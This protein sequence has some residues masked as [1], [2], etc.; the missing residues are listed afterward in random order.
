MIIYSDS[1][2]QE[3]INQTINLVNSKKIF[4]NIN[5]ELCILFCKY[6]LK[7]L[8]IE[9]TNL[10]FEKNKGGSSYINNKIT[11]DEKDLKK[12]TSYYNLDSIAH[13]TRH[14]F[15]DQTKTK[16]SLNSHIEFSYPLEYFNPILFSL[17]TN[18]D[19]NLF[20]FYN[21]SKHESGARNYSLDIIDEFLNSILNSSD[22]VSKSKLWA[23]K[24]ISLNEKA[25]LVEN[26][27]FLKYT[28][29]SKSQQPLIK[30]LVENYINDVINLQNNP[31]IEE[32][33]TSNH[34]IGFLKNIYNKVGTYSPI[35]E[36]ILSLYC[37]DSLTNKLI[38]SA[39]K[40]NDDKEIIICL[41]HSYTNIS[42][43][44]M[45]KCLQYFYKKQGNL[46]NIKEILYNFNE[47]TITDL[48][49]KFSKNS[50]AKYTK[51]SCLSQ[52]NKIEQNQNNQKN[53][54]EMS[55]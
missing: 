39:I 48:S 52:N 15:Q 45:N 38:D 22:K 19:V 4:K 9:S 26:F 43:Q 41:N 25:K 46:D 3:I 30:E 17:I 34:R 7:D 33:S 54:E 23:K 2:K 31:N 5:K 16:K 10:N 50:N 32:I 55:K 6:C 49:K 27:N 37:D 51:K 20:S 13:E 36:A 18:Y 35:V 28:K 24:L 11:I 42:S 14:L 12:R 21:T 8:Q 53:Y 44:T 1:S 47:K 40:F 29:I